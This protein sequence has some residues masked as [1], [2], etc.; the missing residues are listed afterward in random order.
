MIMSSRG[1]GMRKQLLEPSLGWGCGAP[2]TISPGPGPSAGAWGKS[3]TSLREGV[4][5]SV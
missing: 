1:P 4:T 3:W 2:G 5:F